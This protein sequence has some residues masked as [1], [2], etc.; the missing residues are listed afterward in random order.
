MMPGLWRRLRATPP[1]RF[2]ISGARAMNRRSAFIRGVLVSLC[3]VGLSGCA[4]KFNRTNFDS[5]HAGVDTRDDVRKIL[6][7][8]TTSFSDYWTYEGFISTTIARIYFDDDGTVLHTE[9]I[10]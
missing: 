8:P 10:E 3:L 4:S 7:R 5:I 2:A 6:G 9:W 1:A